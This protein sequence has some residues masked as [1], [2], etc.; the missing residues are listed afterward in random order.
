MKPIA[1]VLAIDI[2]IF[3]ILF[4]IVAFLV[5][6][7]VLL[8]VGTGAIAFFNFGALVY[9]GYDRDKDFGLA[10]LAGFMLLG[11]IT[12]LLIWVIFPFYGISSE[13]QGFKYLLGKGITD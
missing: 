6:P 11:G 13:I 3:L 1:I 9:F 5:G 12:A 2:S 7:W 4:L 10:F 8:P